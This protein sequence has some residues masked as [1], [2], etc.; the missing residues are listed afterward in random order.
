[1]SAREHRLD[2]EPPALVRREAL[3]PVGRWTAYRKLALVR[4]IRAGVVGRADA[5]TAHG[6][7]DEELAA[8]ERA[9]DGFGVLGLRACK[10]VFAMRLWRRA[11]LA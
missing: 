2:R 11:G 3:A 9:I 4:A 1:M 5:M 10:G 7:D 6:I 8:W